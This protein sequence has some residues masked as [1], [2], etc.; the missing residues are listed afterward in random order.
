[1]LK[2]LRNRKT[3]KKI[4]IGLGII[5]LPAFI[6]WGFGGTMREKEEKNYAGK[7]PGKKISYS[8][9]RESLS[10]VKVKNMAIMRYGEN[11]GQVFKESDLEA[12]AWQRLALIYEAK[13]LKLKTSD[14]EVVERLESYPFFQHNGKFDNRLYN[15]ILQYVF[16]TQPRVFEEQT[17]QNITIS[18]LF[19]RVTSGIT[20]DDQEVREG[21]TRINS[22]INPKFK[23]E[24]KKFLNEK[25]EFETMV[26]EEKKEEYFSKFTA[27]LLR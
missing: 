22:A 16:R 6:F 9:F 3:A 15:D 17:R 5:I 7:L 2:L 20:V 13:K 24:E 8:E 26:L 18:K 1:M 14:K 25:Q 23:F 21:Y 10:A 12:Q 4:W 19:Q 27:G 11:F